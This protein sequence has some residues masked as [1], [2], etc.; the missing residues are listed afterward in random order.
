MAVDEAP[1]AD[2]GE[3]GDDGPTASAEPSAGPTAAEYQA[4]YGVFWAAFTVPTGSFDAS[5]WTRA[6]AVGEDTGADGDVGGD[7][8]EDEDE[9]V[10]TG[11][12]AA[13]TLEW[14]AGC[15]A[16]YVGR[17]RATLPAPSEAAR[18]QGGEGG[19][20]TDD[21]AGGDAAARRGD[22]TAGGGGAERMGAVGME[23]EGPTDGAAEVGQGAAGMAAADSTD[24]TGGGDGPTKARKKT[25]R[26]KKGGRSQYERQRGARKR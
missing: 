3:M 24:T 11:A 18:P 26:G 17:A 23:V 14:A 22:G 4:R 6:P 2:A 15:A 16:W 8:D 21:A 9:V 12:A 1:A 7:A 5:R 13:P 25:K 10:G 20:G 19:H